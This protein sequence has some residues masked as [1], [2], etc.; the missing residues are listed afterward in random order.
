MPAHEDSQGL[1]NAWLTAILVLLYK[2]K[3]ARLLAGFDE[4]AAPLRSGNFLNR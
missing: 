4:A 2:E 3:G 1:A